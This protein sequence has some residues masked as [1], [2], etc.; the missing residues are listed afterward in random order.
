MIYELSDQ[1]NLII[2]HLPLVKR[3]VSRIDSKNS[4]YDLEDLISIGVIGLM[5]AIKRYDYRKK[6]PFEA[7]ASLRIRGAVIDELRKAGPVSRN[8]IDKLNQYYMVKEK[9]ENQLMRTPSELEIC[10]DMDIDNKELS[11]IH[12]TVHYLANISLESMIFSK[13]GNDTKLIDLIQDEDSISPE[14][15]Y[16]DGE[17]KR[18]LI[19]AIGKLDDR[20]KTILNLYY[21]EELSMKEIA[22]ILDISIPRVSQIH[23]KT[24]LKLRD[25]LSPYMEEA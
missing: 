17:K 22:Y 25:L 15:Y 13:D 6:V 23:G 4:I 3:V 21:V 19:E 12:E 9:L 20:E 2:K 5:D 10:K 18:M 24:L 16:T 11:N 1:D 7:Y 8:R 14:E